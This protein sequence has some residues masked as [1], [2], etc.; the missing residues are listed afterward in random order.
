MVDLPRR[1]TGTGLLGVVVVDY[2]YVV[3]LLGQDHLEL[4]DIRSLGADVEPTVEGE[5][6]VHRHCPPAVQ[7]EEDVSR[8]DGVTV[9]DED[10]ADLA[11]DRRVDHL[12]FIAPELATNRD[13]VGQ[14]AHADHL[15]DGAIR[16]D[17]D[18]QGVI[19]PWLPEGDADCH[20]GEDEQH[21]HLSLH[22]RMPLSL[23]IA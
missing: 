14:G 19:D 9:L 20:Q 16:L 10:I 5:V 4:P 22:R 2:A 17:V 13:L 12:E 18:H 3:A 15:G 6:A 7:G 8:L 23:G 11:V 21:R 1:Q